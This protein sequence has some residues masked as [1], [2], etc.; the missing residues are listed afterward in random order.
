MRTTD[1]RQSDLLLLDAVDVFNAKGVSYAVVGGFAAAVHGVDRGTKDMDVILQ[2]A[3][4][5]L[6]QLVSRL[7]EAGFETELKIGGFDDPIAAVLDVQ[8]AHK[9]CVEILVG[10]KGLPQA[11]FSR[12]I[13]IPFGDSSLRVVGYEDFLAMKLSAGGPQDLLDVDEALKVNPHFN[14]ELVRE[15]VRGYGK[16]AARRFNQAVQRL[17]APKESAEDEDP[18]DLGR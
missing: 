1:K 4:P 2:V 13:E 9:N 6:R 15:L 18:K 7:Q 17:A 14:E 5:E 16:E 12:A 8:D 11:A 10:I 3:L